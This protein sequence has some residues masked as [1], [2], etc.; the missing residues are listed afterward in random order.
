MFH[1]R[2]LPAELEGGYSA[3]F[4]RLRRFFIARGVP[5]E[6]AADMAQ[7]SIARALLHIQRRGTSPEYDGI[8]PL[9]SRIGIN[10]LID[11][12]RAAGPRLVSIDNAE[13]VRDLDADPSDHV[14]RL[15]R[16]ATVRGAIE[17]LSD[18]HRRALELTLQGLTPAEIAADL[19]IGRNAADALLH[20]ARRRLAER[21]SSAVLTVFGTI[22]LRARI[23]A[24]RAAESARSVDAAVGS[25]ALQIGA[26]AVVA[27][28]AAT[29]GL[30]P[31]SNDV[32]GTREGASARSVA[33]A[34]SGDGLVLG[35]RATPAMP[36]T[37]ADGD[38]GRTVRAHVDPR[39]PDVRADAHYDDPLVDE[40]HHTYAG[41]ERKREETST[42]RTGPIVDVLTATAC[43]TGPCDALLE[44]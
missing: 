37:P 3:T 8:G 30:V 28:L 17:Q 26:F 5:R 18:R 14:T 16:Q 11:R 44:E 15:D 22:S 10:L 33:T 25:G 38:A 6:E 36:T 21:L 41:L 27:A 20:R 1:K 42:S 4:E 39:G 12:A 9:L 23:A 29:P 31:G 2:H 24:R 13:S 34:P 40:P 19:G 43:S 35:V 7:E 32:T